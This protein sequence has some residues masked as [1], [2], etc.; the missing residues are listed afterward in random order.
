MY[1]CLKSNI[2]KLM[3]ANIMKTQ[4]FHKMNMLSKVNEDDIRHLYL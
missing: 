4:T 3:N 2:I 1:F